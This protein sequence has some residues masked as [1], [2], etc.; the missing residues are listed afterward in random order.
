MK[1]EKLRRKLQSCNW[2]WINE[3]ANSEKDAKSR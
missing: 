1:N 3:K 2:S